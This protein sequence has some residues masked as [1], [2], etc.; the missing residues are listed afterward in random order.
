MIDG[1]LLL[2]AMMLPMVAAAADSARGELDAAMRSHADYERGA[3]LFARCISCHGRDGNGEA[4]GSVPRLSGQHYRVLLKQLVDFRHRRRDDF[5]MT[6]AGQHQLES[7]QD[8]A[9][10]AL[11]A[12]SQERGGARGIGNG[13]FT[14]LG[15]EIFLERC[16]SCH[17]ADGQ[18]D[19]ARLIPRLAGQHYGYLLRQM[20]DAVDGRR[21][22]MAR[23]HSPR[24]APLDFDEVRAL[25]DYLSR[26]GAS[27]SSSPAP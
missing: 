5:R 17:G 24:V 21:A 12:A 16:R 18:G 22:S 19:D 10:V 13:E 9:D 3:A 23:S 8:L 6:L 20:Y 27:A 2:L 25:A 11:Y 15:R 1:R 26:I 4:S 7:P 14:E